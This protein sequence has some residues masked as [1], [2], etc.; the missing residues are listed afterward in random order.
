MAFVA[1]VRAMGLHTALVTASRNRAAVL[2]ASGTETL[3]DAFVDGDD[4][5]ALGLPGKPAPDMF[6]EA[7]RRL[8]VDPAHAIVVEDA[9]AGVEAARRGG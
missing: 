1:R 3:F 2:R 5:A 4:A 7:A 8:D 9:L 6:L